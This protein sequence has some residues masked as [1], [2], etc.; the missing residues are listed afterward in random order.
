M[1]Y[2]ALL[3]LVII[4]CP[5]AVGQRIYDI[6]AARDYCDSTALHLIEGIWEFPEDETKVL[7][8]RSSFDPH[9]YDII[10]LSSPDC[11]I[12]PSESIGKIRRSPDPVKYELSL[13][14]SRKGGILT[15]MRSCL[16]NFNNKEGSLSIQPKKFKISLRS[17]Y[18][19]PRFWRMLSVRTDNP[20]E[21]LPQGL[22][23]IY[24]QSKF[25]NPIY[26]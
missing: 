10:A 23:R 9:A 11:R 7:I 24:P 2:S 15:D 22:I 17:L 8:M 26:L 6:Q 13:Y 21:R 14:C 12:I 20:L 1:K 19:L 4:L 5:T 25:R 3:L 16:A 18:L